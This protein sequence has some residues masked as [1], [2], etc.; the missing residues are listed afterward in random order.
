MCYGSRD[1]LLVSLFACSAPL[2]DVFRL[3]T[4]SLGLNRGLPFSVGVL[5]SYWTS[6]LFKG[7]EGS[8]SILTLAATLQVCWK[9][10]QKD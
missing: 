8:E 2:T 3:T 6:E 7:V 1:A 9:A 4:C 10:D 5:H